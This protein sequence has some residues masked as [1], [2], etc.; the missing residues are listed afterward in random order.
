MTGQ[1]TDGGEHEVAGGWIKERRGTPVPLF[2]KLA[3]VGLSI[4]GIVYLLLY[5]YGE[6]NHATRGPLV[7]QANLAMDRPGAAWIGFLCVVLLT[8]AAGL[9]A[10]AF[11][12][13]GQEE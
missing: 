6:V 13:A 12:K 7:Q 5:T 8:F 9:L 11:R 4:F 10:L 1:A 3:Y 2:L